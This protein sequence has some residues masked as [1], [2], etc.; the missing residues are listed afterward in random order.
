MIK[1]I[2]YCLNT[3]FFP[4]VGTFVQEGLYRY[5]VKNGRQN[6][7]EQKNLQTDFKGCL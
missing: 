7:N 5:G 3:Y 2:N 6:K 1:Q 4:I